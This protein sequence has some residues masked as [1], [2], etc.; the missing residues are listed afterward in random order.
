MKGTMTITADERRLHIEGNLLYQNNAEKYEIL[1]G[2]A[3][4]LAIRGPKDWAEATIYACMRD[5]GGNKG[6]DL[7]QTRSVVFVKKEENKNETDSN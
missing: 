7:Q 2:V 6:V 3:Q 1:Y 4:C 5:T